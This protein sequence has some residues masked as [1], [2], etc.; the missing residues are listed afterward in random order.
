MISIRYNS[1]GKERT[2]ERKMREQSDILGTFATFCQSCKDEKSSPALSP[3]T[4]S[5]TL[6]SYGQRI[7]IARS[8]NTALDDSEGANPPVYEKYQGQQDACSKNPSCYLEADD[9]LDLT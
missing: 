5:Y 2:F 6:Y 3:C 9:W 4:R 1:M 8:D 7:Q